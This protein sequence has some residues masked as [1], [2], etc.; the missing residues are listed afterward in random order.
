VEIAWRDPGRA[1]RWRVPGIRPLGERQ[2]DRSTRN[3]SEVWT[4]VVNLAD[5]N[6]QLERT[7][8][9][10]MICAGVIA[11]VGVL[12]GSS[13]LIVGAMAIS[14]DLLLISASAIGPVE[15]RWWLAAR[16]GRALAIGL[17]IGALASC[18]ATLALRIG[19]RIPEDLVLADPAL[20]ASL[21]R[22]GPGS[23]LVAADPIGHRFAAIH[24]RAS[25]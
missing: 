22:L 23:L 2:R 18:A 20:G 8:V 6:S 1:A 21:T 24:A 5:E 13:I 9:L 12:T 14:P 4:E 19:D 11:G 15:R 17:G 25:A 10:F 3:D 7:Y 16:A